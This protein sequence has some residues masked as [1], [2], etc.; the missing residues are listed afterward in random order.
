MPVPR[1]MTTTCDSPR[2]AP[3]HASA[4]AAALASLS[5]VIGSVDALGEAHRAAARCA[6]TGAA[7]RRRWR[8]PRR[9]SPRRRCPLRRRRRGRPVAAAPRRTRRWCPRPP[10]A[11]SSGAA[12]RDGCGAGSLPS[13]RRRRRRPSCPRCRCRWQ[14]VS[15]C[16]VSRS[17]PVRGWCCVGCGLV[18]GLGSGVGMGLWPP[19][20]LRGG[21]VAQRR[22]READEVG[23]LVDGVGVDLLH[24]GD[25][26]ADRAHPA[27]SGRR[28]SARA[29][30]RTPVGPACRAVLPA[31]LAAVTGVPA[32]ARGAVLAARGTVGSVAPGRG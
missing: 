16:A 11:R 10:G 23:D 14:V 12:C 5:T 20:A 17:G 9:R 21:E 32:V 7:R 8:G 13:R 18:G 4:Q 19:L 31:G 15:S 25:E 26:L 2:A 1:V 6:T 28:A 3:K 29:L 24:E 30:P 22:G 27:R